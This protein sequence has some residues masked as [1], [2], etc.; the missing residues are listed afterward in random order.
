MLKKDEALDNMFR[1]MNDLETTIKQGE[2]KNQS[3]LSDIRQIVYPTIR[4]MLYLDKNTKLVE[5]EIVSKA[6]KLLKIAANHKD[7]FI[8]LVEGQDFE[9][10][11]WNNILETANKEPFVW[12][13]LIERSIIRAIQIINEGDIYTGFNHLLAAGLELPDGLFEEENL[14]IQSLTK[15]LNS[16]NEKLVYWVMSILWGQDYCFPAVIKGFQ[17][18]LQHKDWRIRVI[19]WECLRTWNRV[20]KL[21]IPLKPKLDFADRMKQRIFRNFESTLMSPPN[22]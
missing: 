4:D 14:A 12:K 7:E 9:N 22:L 8:A 20:H 16:S 11:I 1:A 13:K 10:S 18:N 2:I 21:N 5:Q 6:E 17:N 15:E 3:Y 19:T